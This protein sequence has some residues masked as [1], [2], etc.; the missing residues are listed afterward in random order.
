MVKNIIKKTKSILFANPKLLYENEKDL[1]NDEFY[2]KGHNKKAVL[3]LHG[4]TATPYELRRLGIFLNESGYTVYG[5]LLRGHGTKPSDL[6]NV[7]F[8]DWLDDAREAYFRLKSNHKKVFIGGT[9]M[10]GT[11]TLCLAKEI[12]DIGGL[13]LMATP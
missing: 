9:S 13:I 7:K 12:D 2:F 6:E 11:V 10:G 1:V 4:W 5:P 8:Q 3:L